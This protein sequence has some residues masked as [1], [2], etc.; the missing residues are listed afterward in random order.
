MRSAVITGCNTVN[1]GVLLSGGPSVRTDG[2]AFLNTACLQADSGSSEQR[3]GT[4]F[5]FDGVDAD[6]K[7]G[8]GWGV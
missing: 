6:K 5:S 4:S 3:T 7:P 8:D 2:S 1:G